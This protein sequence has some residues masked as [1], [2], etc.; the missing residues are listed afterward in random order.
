M[1]HNTQKALSSLD[2]V[3]AESITPSR[4]DDEF[5]L[6]EYIVKSK[7]PRST[8]KE[9]LDNLVRSGVLSKRKISINGSLCNL[10]KKT[11]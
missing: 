9:H 11:C 3:I 1:K 7:M 10:F 6:S 2:F 5:T 4:I 8:A